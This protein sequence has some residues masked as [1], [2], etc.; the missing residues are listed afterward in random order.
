MVAGNT[1]TDQLIDLIYACLVGE[2]TWQGFLDTLSGHVPDGGSTLFFHDRSG[3]GAASLTSQFSQKSL[4]EYAEYYSRLNP[5]MRKV[6]ETPLG[7]GIVGERIVDRGNFQ[8]TEYYTDFIRRNGFETGI[9]VTVFRDEDC[10]FLLSTLTARAD[11]EQNQIAADQL[12][13]LVP[14]LRRVFRHY[15]SGPIRTVSRDIG[16]S[17]FESDTAGLMIVGEGMS[18]KAISLS[19]ERILAQNRL[20]TTDLMGKLKIRDQA[21]QA[22]L[23]SMLNRR[24]DGT[25]VWETRL[26]HHRISLTRVRGDSISEYF[27]GPTV[28]MIVEGQPDQS[29]ALDASRLTERYGLSRAEARVAHGIISGQTISEIAQA[30]S[31]SRETTRVQLKSVYAKTGVNSQS[32]LIRLAIQPVPA[33]SSESDQF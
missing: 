32:A 5:W 10:S 21:A 26:G 22:V 25:R 16:V 15:R 13:A 2:A 17:L 6:A 23:Q 1:S 31:V 24:Y 27:A 20:V 29:Y 14:H 9:G 33:S 4:Q 7:I 12:T 18:L 11:P 28:L 19:A 3:Y 30:A 8:L